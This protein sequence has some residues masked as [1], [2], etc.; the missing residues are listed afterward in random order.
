MGRSV[1]AGG[2]ERRRQYET[3]PL[4]AVGRVPQDAE[5]RPGAERQADTGGRAHVVGDGEKVVGKQVVVPPAGERVALAVPAER[6]Q[7]AGAG[8]TQGERPGLGRRAAE[9]VGEQRDG[10]AR[11]DDG[12]LHTRHPPRGQYCTHRHVSDPSRG[13]R[14]PAA[15]RR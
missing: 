3:E 13:H 14:R 15:R 7:H 2:V 5:Q 9:A 6:H 8:N 1:R 10:A 12:E 4:E 11:A